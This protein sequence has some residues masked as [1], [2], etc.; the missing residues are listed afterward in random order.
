MLAMELWDGM[1]VL[2][3]LGLSLLHLPLNAPPP[4]PSF[5]NGNL[6]SGMLFGYGL[7]PRGCVEGLGPA[8]DTFG[9]WAL[10]ML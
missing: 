4:I 5:W 1:T 3:G 10:V 9:G 6:H 8:D 7:S 2:L